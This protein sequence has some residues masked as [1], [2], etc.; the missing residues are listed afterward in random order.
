M[1]RRFMGVIPPV[2]TIFFPDG[3]L[4]K[5]GMG[6]NIDY[7]IGQG[8]HALFFNGTGGEFSQMSQSL[9][10][11]VAAFVVGYVS[12]RLPVL[13]GTGS[14][15]TAEV[16]ELNDHAKSLGAD[17]V[18]VI[19]P[20][21]W[22]LSEAHLFAHYDDIAKATDLPI[23][24]Y[25]FPALTGQDLSP[26]F[27]ARLVAKHPHIVGIK[28]TVDSVN[29]LNFMIEKVKAVSPDFAVLAGFD[30]YLMHTLTM[31]GDG[32]IAAA[33]NFLPKLQVDVYNAYVT[34]DHAQA[35][36]LQQQLSITTKLHAI[37]SPFVNVIKEATKI[38]TGFDF[39]TYVLPPSRPLSADK[40]QLV[41]DILAEVAHG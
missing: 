22:T 18:V 10:R 27:V 33:G 2:S 4:D 6:R 40:I 35:V 20:Y 36:R 28:D 32:I 19:N 34:G 41:S 24:L 29:H 25:N 11:E 14:C 17:G 26:E 8:V 12:G 23:V 7:L 5:Q 13:I 16:I 21:Y 37:D 1:L 30:N 9:R 38:T 39:S 3:T 31:G 15:S